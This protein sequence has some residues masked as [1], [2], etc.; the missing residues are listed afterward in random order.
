M[1]MNELSLAPVERFL[2]GLGVTEPSDIDV[3]AIAWASGARVKYCEL[4]GCEA[5]ILG[6]KGQAIIRV[7]RRL[8]PHRKRFSIAHELGHWCHHRHRMSWCTADDIGNLGRAASEIERVADR[9][10]ADLLMPRYIFNPLAQKHAH[11]DTQVVREMARLFSTSL[12]A[13]G[14]R[15]VMSGLWTALLVCH[16]QRGRKWFVRS[17]DVPERWFPRA[18][19][20]PASFSFDLLFGSEAELLRPRKVGAEAWFDQ[21]EA[22]KYELHEQAVRTSRGEV[23][24][25]LLLNDLRMLEEQ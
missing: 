13:T 14:I 9:Y 10:A 4:D 19:L 20:D 8:S 2:K 21:R 23:I 22:H 6:F 18:E 15:L 5:R 11:L 3:E 16:G 1:L 7:D 17:P 12:T 25:L 24:T